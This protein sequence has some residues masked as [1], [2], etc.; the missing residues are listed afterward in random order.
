MSDTFERITYYPVLQSSEVAAAGFYTVVM[1]GFIHPQ[2]ATSP[3]V[4]IRISKAEAT[5][6]ISS[7]DN[8]AN[9]VS[10]SLLYNSDPLFA[11]DIISSVQFNLFLHGTNFSQRL[12]FCRFVQM[13]MHHM[14][15]D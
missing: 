12:F 13:M 5:L 6:E 4:W 14:L 1:K 8:P 15:R 2:G 11:L 10:V 7:D 9:A 3:S